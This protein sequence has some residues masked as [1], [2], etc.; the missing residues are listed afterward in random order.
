MSETTQKRARAMV[1]NAAR[2][3]AFAALL[4][5]ESAD[6]I[7]EIGSLIAK[8][9]ASGSKILVFGNGGSA[10]CATH[11]AA[12]FSGKL[13]IDRTP[14]SAISLCTDM[15]AITA[16]ANDYG[17]D[18]IF[19]RQARAHTKAGDIVIG[20]ST[21]GK[22]S[23]V[24]RALKVAAE[25]GA[26]TVALV[27]SHSSLE[28]SYTLYVPLHETARVQEAHDLILHEI[29]QVAERELNPSLG[30]DSSADPFP[31]VLDY[32]QADAYSRWARETDQNLV[33]SN[34]VFD[35]LHAG[36]RKSL[37]MASELGD[38]LVVL[39]NADETVRAL[40]GDNRPVRDQGER[41]RDLQM[42]PWVAHVVIFSET[43]PRVIL[44]ILK[45]AVHVKGADYAEKQ[46]VEESTVVRNGGRVMI[47]NSGSIQ[48]T[49]SQVSKIRG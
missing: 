19:A 46:L 2:R 31:F 44:D 5:E 10:A 14:Y 8:A 18:E 15:S 34:G 39:V 25:L 26:K 37:L 47:L 49:S 30:P 35:L 22:S 45:P 32:T 33:T 6:A 28:S 1:Q 21:S 3:L 40:K 20:L 29:A 48:S 7:A 12:E 38:R 23:N 24:N 13:K 41:V 16:I 4:V 17:F 43:D 27:G 11:F 36:H 42:L 9:L